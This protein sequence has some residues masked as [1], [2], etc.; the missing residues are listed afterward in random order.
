LI[1]ALLDANVLIALVVSE[2]VHHAAAEQWLHGFDGSFATCPMTQ[3]SLLRLLLR[4]GVDAGTAVATL[5]A[6]TDHR[7]HEFW[8]DDIAYTEVRTR[9][10]V[11]H[12]QVTDAYLAQLSRRHNGRLVT[13]DRGL[14]AL[15]HDVAELIGA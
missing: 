13:F 6:L 9:G 3:C 11:G 8:P 7:R 12:R 4:E 5:R 10:V 1:A 15:H 14:A 2:H